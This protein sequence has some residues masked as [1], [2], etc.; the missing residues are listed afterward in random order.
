MIRRT[1][2]RWLRIA[3]ATTLVVA[4]APLTAGGATAAADTIGPEAEKRRITIC[5][6]TASTTNPYVVISPAKMSIVKEAGHDSHDGPVFPATGEDGKWGDIIP[7]FS[8]YASEQDRRSGASPQTYPGQNWTAEGQAAYAAGCEFEDTS[9][10]TNPEG[11]IDGECVEE[12][13]DFVVSGSVEDGRGASTRFRLLITEPDTTTEKTRAVTD[14]DLEEGVVIDAPAGTTVQLQYARGGSETWT[15][16]DGAVT[17]TECGPQTVNASGGF[18]TVCTPTAAQATIG[19][20][21]EGTFRNGS[22]RLVGA[23]FSATVTSGQTLAVPASTE[24]VLQ[25]VP[26]EQSAAARELDR[27]TSPAACPEQGT[28]D[29]DSTPAPGSVVAPGS[30]IDYRVTVA[31]TGQLALTAKPVVDTLPQFV[32]VQGSPSDGGQVSSD[33]RSITWTVTLAPGASKTFTYT[34]LVSATAPAGTVLVNEATFLGLRDTTSHTVGSRSLE[35]V[36]GVDKAT[37]TF[38]ETLT[39]TLTVRALGNLAQS[40][41]VVTDA[42]PAGTSYVLGSVRC[43]DSGTCNPTVAN[44]VVNWALGTMAAGTTRTLSFQVTIDR[45]AADAN[46]AIPAVTVLN[47]GSVRSTEVGAT[48]SNEVRTTVAAVA[49]VKVSAPD[50]AGGVT[51][52]VGVEGTKSGPVELAATGASVSTGTIAGLG[53]LLLLM[54]AV[55]MRVATSGAARA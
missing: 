54:G 15:N 32:T 6:R 26:S 35:L 33:G 5:H 3:G 17:V 44:G 24:L 8:Y 45:P 38:G 30:T 11:S 40:D 16:L 18:S 7:P 41:V 29:K 21:A 31:N 51:P 39:Y 55:L 52:D 4:L 9:E 14:A 47:S 19:T 36:K 25:Y 46:G 50:T 34:G 43:L 13:G 12:T 53:G 48:P 23:N 2:G 49:G 27:E 37:A 42:I 1:V 20:L 28:L 22:F 10:E